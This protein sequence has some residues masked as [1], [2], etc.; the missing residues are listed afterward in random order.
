MERVEGEP[1]SGHLKNL[2][3]RGEPT[4]TVRRALRHTGSWL[5]HYHG[6]PPS[7]GSQVR[8]SRRDEVVAAHRRLWEF[9]TETQR[10]AGF[11]RE[12]GAA[13]EAFAKNRVP[14]ELEVGRIHGDFWPGNV[15]VGPAERVTV[16][17]SVM[18]AITPVQLDVARFLRLL[19]AAPANVYSGGRLSSRHTLAELEAEFLR[20]YYGD[21]TDPLLD[22]FRLG[23]CLH[24]WTRAAHAA[25][26]R[27]GSAGWSRRWRLALKRSFYRRAVRELVH[28]LA[29]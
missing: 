25:H 16:I 9:L 7:P 18:R 1:L 19:Q 20:G 29:T 22:W 5:R 23:S 10:P 6:L 27:A 3:L 11:F 15:L 4:E 21:S 24:D 28:R 17:D 8:L 26:T 14:E 13:F 12:V 2:G